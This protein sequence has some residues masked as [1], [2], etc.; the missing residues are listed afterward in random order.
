MIRAKDSFKTRVSIK[1]PLTPAE[2]DTA[3]GILLAQAQQDVFAAEFKALMDKVDVHSKSSMMNL[4]PIIDDYAGVPVIK[5]GGRLWQGSF[6][7]SLANSSTYLIIMSRKTA[8]Q[9]QNCV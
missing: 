2:I 5:V 3:E 6:E 4:N 1:T 8:V 9:L 7:D